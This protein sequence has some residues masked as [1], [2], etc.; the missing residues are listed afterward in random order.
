MI[1]GNLGKMGEMMKQ[2]KEIRDEMKKAR[3]EGEAGG[4]KVV[5]NGEMEI[6]EVTSP[7]DVNSA[8][9]PSLFKDAANR[10]LKSAKDDMQKRLG[11]LTGGLSLP[12]LFS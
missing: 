1:F 4:V 6:L 2:A 11:K 10:A 9:A 8:K 3:Y 7:P 12:G 5:V